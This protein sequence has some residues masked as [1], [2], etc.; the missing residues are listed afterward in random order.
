M[1]GFR[2]DN[3]TT[4]RTTAKN[5]SLVV[6]AVSNATLTVTAAAGAAG[7]VGNTKRIVINT[8]GGGNCEIQEAQRIADAIAET[9]ASLG[10][11]L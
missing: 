6:N 8:G 1:R 7:E 10:T 2:A 9:L 11:R 5:A 3:L 4:K